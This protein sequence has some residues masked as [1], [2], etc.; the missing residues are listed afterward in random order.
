VITFTILGIT[1]HLSIGGHVIGVITR[2]AQSFHALKILCSYGM[3]NN[4]LDVFN[5]AVV[6]AKVL[7]AIPTWWL[8]AAAS[9]RE[10]L[11]A[12]IRHGIHLTFYC[13]DNPTVVELV[14]EL[15]ETL[16]TAVTQNSFSVLSQ[17][18]DWEERLRNELFC[19]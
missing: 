16:F 10:K 18:I 17:E 13:H 8:F 19:V 15:D 3:S 2:Y 11:Y 14:E 4:A 7:Y 1:N 12:F 5:K 6:I 9:D